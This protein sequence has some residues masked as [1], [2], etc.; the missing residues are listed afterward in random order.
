M[1]ARESDLQSPLWNEDIQ[2]LAP[3][4][5]PHGSDSM[6]LDNVLELLTHSG[7]DILHAMM[8]LIPEAYEQIPDMP[9]VLKACYEYLSCVSEPWDGP[10]AVAFTDGVVVGACLDRNGLRPARYKVTDDG[11]VVMGSEVGIIELDDSRVVEKGRLG[12]GQMIA[13][14]TAQGKLLKDSEIKHG[15]AE[16]K[17][18]AKWVQKGIVTLPTIKEDPSPITETPPAVSYTH[19]TLPTIYSV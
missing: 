4:I 16:R 11:I 3:I 5:N 17:P 6:S 1:R 13:V 19:L 15:I 9:D 10:A 18:Y 7:R 8:C 2:K 14:D 12:P